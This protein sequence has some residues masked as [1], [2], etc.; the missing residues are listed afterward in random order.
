M[1]RKI[2]QACAGVLAAIG[3][4]ACEMTKS[5]H[6]LG[7]TVAGPI[8][9]VNITSP[10]PL[11]PAQGLKI[12]VEL[13]PITLM[14][15]N[16]ATTGVRPLNYLFEVATDAGF[17]NKV[18]SRDGVTPGASGRTTLRL[19]NALAPERSYYWRA[20]AQDGANTG[21]YSAAAFFNIFTPVVLGKPIL[22]EPVNVTAVSQQPTLKFA[23][24]PRSGP[25]APIT[26]EI[27][28]AEN[29]A[30]SPSV[31]IWAVDEVPGRRPL[32]CRCY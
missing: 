31:G 14:L 10:T 12:A 6:P 4:S 11:E 7:P 3:V 30:F 32:R 17:S 24:A 20:R 26:Y 16:A 5:E 19:P 15:T 29:E 21:P 27:Q 23:N 28:L 18:F 8:P 25:A 1:S 22:Q 9:G 2:L 13:Q